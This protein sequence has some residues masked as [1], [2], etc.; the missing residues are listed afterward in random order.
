MRALL[1]DLAG[2]SLDGKD[3]S[4]KPGSFSPCPALLAL[5]STKIQEQN[6]GGE[7]LSRSD[8]TDIINYLVWEGMSQTEAETHYNLIMEQLE[9]RSVAQQGYVSPKSRI[10]R[11]DEDN[12]H[13]GKDLTAPEDM[14]NREQLTLEQLENFDMEIP[15]A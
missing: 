3:L 14:I 2:S 10:F 1:K 8:K 5:E 15:G 11:R 9:L 12:P 6:A 4:H 7:S 13:Y